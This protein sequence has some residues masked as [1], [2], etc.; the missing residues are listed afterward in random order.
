MSFFHFKFHDQTGANDNKFQNS[1]VRFWGTNIVLK[2][3]VKTNNM[4]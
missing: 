2:K 4:T 1:Y 3:L